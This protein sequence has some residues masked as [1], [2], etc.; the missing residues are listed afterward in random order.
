MIEKEAELLKKQNNKLQL[1][2]VVL[3]IKNP[4]VEDKKG[5]SGNINQIIKSVKTTNDGVILNNYKDPYISDVYVVFE[6]EQIHILGSKEDIERFKKYMEFKNNAK[7]YFNLSDE[8]SNFVSDISNINL[9][10]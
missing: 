2:T 6:S 9:T 7:D 3:N 5:E 10:C 8:D 4:K 1:F